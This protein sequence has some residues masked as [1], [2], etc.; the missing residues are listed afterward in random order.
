VS[1]YLAER[2]EK[3]QF[4]KIN[5]LLRGRG[6][7]HAGVIGWDSEQDTATARPML[8][9]FSLTG[10]A[11]DVILKTIPPDRNA[12]WDV[13]MTFVHDTCTRKDTEYLVVG[14]NLKYEWTQLFGEF[15]TDL[16]SLDEFEFSYQYRDAPGLPIAATY[17]VRVMNDKRYG[18]V[19]TNDATHRRVRI[20]DAAAYYTGGLD[21]VAKMLGVGRKVELASKRFTKADLDNPLFLEYARQDAYITR[22]IGEEIIDLHDTYDV[23]T[24]ITAPHFAARVFRRHFLSTEVALPDPDLEQ[25]GLYAYHGGKNGYYLDGPKHLTGV[26][27]Y[28][29]TS[30]Y[31]EA[32]RALPNIETATWEWTEGYTAGAHALWKITGAFTRCKYG[33]LMQHGNAW[34]DTGTIT[35][36]WVTSYELDAVLARGEIELTRCDGWVMNGEPGGPL[37]AYV[38]R[39]FAMKRTATGAARIAAKLF[40]NSLYGK[41]FQKVPL[42]IVGYYDAD[43]LDELGQVT[44]IATD[45]T[46][47]F[48]YQA[49]GLY[50]PPIAALI[51]GYVRA[52]IHALEHKYGAVMTSTD[53]FFAVRAPDP[54]DVGTDLGA[55]TV[56]RGDLSIWRERLYDFIPRGGGASKYALHGFRGN[57]D[58][59]RR[60]PLAVGAYSYHAQQVIT[61]KLALKAFR[62]VRFRPGTF[63]QLEFT[64]ILT[65]RAPP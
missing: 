46:A 58:A 15:P 26:Y 65:D 12:A 41:F 24:C 34:H 10:G 4:F 32:M 22:L 28:D 13:F 54:A 48:D 9:Q 36:A 19:I 1:T 17:T 59:L 39:F 45:P 23:P 61:N 35:D 53:G 33:G 8:F 14:F 27:A 25:A 42:G 62:G 43:T 51:T 20:M 29:I 40:L 55:L 16:N 3:P 56:E 18:C 30:A 11:D 38:D 52:K 5:P 57:L 44:Y 31:P 64:L 60:I 7:R 37:T 2:I 21:S 49:G 6:N 47:T 63:A 50:H